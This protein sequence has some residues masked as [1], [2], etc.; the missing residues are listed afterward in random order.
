M[1]ENNDYLNLIT[2]HI[3]IDKILSSSNPKYHPQI[4]KLLDKKSIIK[5]KNGLFAGIQLN[6]INRKIDKLKNK[7]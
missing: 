6:K 5:E 1:E 3:E 4:K 7:K 2:K